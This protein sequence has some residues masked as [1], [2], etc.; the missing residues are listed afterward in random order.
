MRSEQEIRERLKLAKK[1]LGIA[2]Q[3]QP[4]GWYDDMEVIEWNE[5]WKSIDS[6]IRTIEWILEIKYEN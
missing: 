5:L 6:E 3:N 1:E 2:E 4:Q